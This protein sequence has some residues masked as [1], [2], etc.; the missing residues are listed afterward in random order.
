MIWKTQ[1][2][3]LS[4]G[5]KTMV[6]QVS[7]QPVRLSIWDWILIVGITVS[8]MNELRI[9][10]IG[11]GEA[12]IALWCLGH[13]RD[14]F[15]L[16][17]SHF[18]VRFW[19][20]FLAVITLG[21]LYCRS[22]YPRESSADGLLTFA[23][24]FFISIGI[25][26]GLL[27][28]S[29]REIKRLYYTLGI[30]CA[31]WYYFLYIYSN[32]VS[33][34]FLG[35]NLWYYNSRF[36]GGANNPHQVAV[37]L[38]SIF[39]SDITQLTDSQI[40]PEKKILPLL[41]GVACIILA[42]ATKSSTLLAAFAVSLT[43]FAYYLIMK[44]LSDRRQR[45]LV[46]S[47]LL[48]ILILFVSLFRGW[49]IR[50]SYEW[51]ESDAN[52]LGR[53]SIFKSITF[54]LQKNWLIGLGPGVHGY[55]GRIEYHNSYLEILAMGGVI[56]IIIFAVF[57]VRL[58]KR[59][60]VSPDMLFGMIPVYAYGLGGF[61]MRRSIFWVMCAILTAYA[62]NLLSER[63]AASEPPGER[64]RAMRFKTEKQFGKIH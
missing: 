32:T 12:L 8:P 57:T 37:T 29:S 23:Y 15:N 54:T 22:N 59:L 17:L 41:A 58:S 16:R 36:S 49:I 3:S 50:M 52:G 33:R 19:V 45:W 10:K 39:F 44:K 18:F 60:S 46:S 26:S 34:T 5:D 40:R 56:G 48:A 13:W 64:S 6:Q 31:G 1:A 35:A 24:F 47:V 38:S 21:M 53:L 7:E 4:N 14:I 51:L 20:P 30:V 27:N 63:A 55:N 28:K 43:L 25:Y 61:S 42:L 2:G 62:D 9:W 11:P